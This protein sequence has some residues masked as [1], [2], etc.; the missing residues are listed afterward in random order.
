MCIVFIFRIKRKHF[1]ILCCNK[2]N[3]VSN[4]YE[5]STLFAFDFATLLAHTMQCK[6]MQD[7]IHGI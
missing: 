6:G 4:F 7:A 1:T 2:H 5:I 3:V